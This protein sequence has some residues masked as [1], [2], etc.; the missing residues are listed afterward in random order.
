MSQ[1]LSPQ[2][3]PIEDEVFY[4]EDGHTLKMDADLA[5]KLAG[6]EAFVAQQTAPGLST[7]NLEQQN[8]L[9]ALL[10]DPLP[11]LPDRHS[12][13]DALLAQTRREFSEGILDT[14]GL[15]PRI[16]LSPDTNPTNP[17]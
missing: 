7:I 6:A 2:P 1:E 3:D 12:C 8:E 15:D 11:I 10:S 17:V 4:D 9:L 14:K 5:A 16:Y 13:V